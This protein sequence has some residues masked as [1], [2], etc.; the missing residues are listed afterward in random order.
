MV[1]TPLDLQKGRDFR[2][3]VRGYNTRE[4]DNF[5][6][7][8]LRDY[9]Q[10]YRQNQEL[11]EQLEELKEKLNQYAIIEDTLQKTLVLAQETAEEVKQNAE[12]EAS[13][14]VDKARLHGENIVRASERQVNELREEYQRLQQLEAAYRTQL[15]AFFQAQLLLL[16]QQLAE[17]EVVTP[18]PGPSEERTAVD[19]MDL[20]QG[21]A[22]VAVCVDEEERQSLGL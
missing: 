7:R 15:K 4:V 20:Y 21:E 13:L 9:E 16:D 10:I 2:K 3:S 8:V 6:N 17:A 11:Q 18:E 12:K 22:E 5:M 1:A 14:I 19:D